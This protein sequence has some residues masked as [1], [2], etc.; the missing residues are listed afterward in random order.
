MKKRYAVVLWVAVL[1]CRPFRLPLGRPT[2]AATGRR[3]ARGLDH[4]SGSHLLGA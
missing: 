1:A 3:P 4:R 2:D